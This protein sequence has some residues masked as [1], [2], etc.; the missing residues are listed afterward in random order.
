[1]LVKSLKPQCPSHR[2]EVEDKLREPGRGVCEGKKNVWEED[3]EEQAL[4]ARLHPGGGGEVTLRTRTSGL[5][6]LAAQDRDLRQWVSM[7]QERCSEGLPFRHGCLS[8]CLSGARQ[9]RHTSR[10]DPTEEP[11]GVSM[12]YLN[13]CTTA[14]YAGARFR[15]GVGGCTPVPR[16]MPS[17]IQPASCLRAEPSTQKQP[18]CAES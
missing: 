16:N 10:T 7:S 11:L 15:L 5:P 14:S 1:M 13:P 12:P 9:E 4:Q 6:V 18:G 3:V 2:K 17:L 8:V